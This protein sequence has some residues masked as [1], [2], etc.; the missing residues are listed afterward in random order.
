MHLQSLGFQQ[1]IDVNELAI[2]LDKDAKSRA[3]F[4]FLI[5]NIGTEIQNFEK[6]SYENIYNDIQRNQIIRV[7]D[8]EPDTNLQIKELE[9]EIMILDAQTELITNKMESQNN[10][11]SLAG[12]KNDQQQMIDQIIREQGIKVNDACE[13]VELETLEIQ[14][15]S[16][17]FI[18]EYISLS[19]QEQ[20]QHQQYVLKAL[21]EQNKDKILVQ[22]LNN[23]SYQLDNYLKEN[24]EWISEILNQLR[25]N[26][27]N[28]VD[29]QQLRQDSEQNDSDE[30][31]QIELEKKSL[32]S[33]MELCHNQLF[34]VWKDNLTHQI[35]YQRWKQTFESLEKL[36]KTKKSFSALPQAA[37]SEVDNDKFAIIQEQFKETFEQVL[38]QHKEQLD[39]K[40][41]ILNQEIIAKTEL[42]QDNQADQILLQNIK[43]VEQRMTEVQSIVNLA[44]ILVEWD[45]YETQIIFDKLQR[46][47]EL[48][49]QISVTQEQKEGDLNDTLKVYHEMNND[50]ATLDG[51]DKL[52]VGVS[53]LI[54]KFSPESKTHKGN[55]DLFMYKQDLLDQ[56]EE[57]ASKERQLKEQN[58]VENIDKNLMSTIYEILKQ[59]K[60]LKKGEILGHYMASDDQYKLLTMLLNQ[61]QSNLSD[62]SRIL[63][64]DQ[65]M[66]QVQ[67]NGLII[68]QEE[69]ITDFLNH[70]SEK[71]KAILK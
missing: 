19:Q 2:I 38:F 8:Q 44:Q 67:K 63:K 32:L 53:N 24:Q 52:L 65:I 56:M 40:F 9:N 31:E 22:T 30:I 33:E 28:R 62:Q 25:V 27:Q 7:L 51:R 41:D 45:Q 29:I 14:E 48:C 6:K 68:R 46:L 71:I 58:Q 47:V 59:S 16:S 60:S 12:N 17:K 39:L 35:S 69:V 55:K 5:G 4:E 43:Q 23:V 20:T 57:I 64:D 36:K 11:E 54:E 61:L 15:F 21:L 26:T 37:K 3:L 13:Q 70:K 42:L 34:K 49:Q 10:R 50:R 66:N 1:Q 18:D